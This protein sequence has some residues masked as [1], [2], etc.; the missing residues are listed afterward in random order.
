MNL[1]PLQKQ[2]VLLKFET[3][4]QHEVKFMNVVFFA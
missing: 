2:R 4:L 3:A 1:G